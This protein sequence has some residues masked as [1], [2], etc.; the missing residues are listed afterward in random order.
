MTTDD[1]TG[2][3]DLF[4]GEEEKPAAEEPAESGGK[5][6]SR[7]GWIV[8][9]V[10]LVAIATVVTVAVLRSQGIKVDVLL[11]VFAY[12]A[13]RLLMKA[14][15]DVAPP[16][17]PRRGPGNGTGGA[18]EASGDSLR[19]AVRRWEYQLGHAQ[20][21]PDRFSRIV[22]PALGEL[23]DERLRL[24]HG[25]TRATDPQRARELLGEPLWQLLNETGRRSPKPREVSAWIDALERI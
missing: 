17:L 3:A 15:S 18:A 25:I 1:D 10:L 21:E 12:S 9:G 24:R 14:V 7:F 13:L 16:P 8:R 22:L 2:L 23:T 19:T 4:A 6:R 5:R 11:V 20:N